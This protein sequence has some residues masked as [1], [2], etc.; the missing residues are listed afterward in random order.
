MSDDPLAGPDP[1]RAHA[2]ERE[3][4]QMAKETALRNERIRIARASGWPLDRIARAAG[5]TR[6]RV[7]QIT[8]EE[9]A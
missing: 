5:I 7:H 1:F 3:R 6:Q 8:T 9:T 4:Q 2:I